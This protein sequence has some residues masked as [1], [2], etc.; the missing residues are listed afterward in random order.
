[1]EGVVVTARRDDANFSV[2]VVS[3]AQ[4]QYRFPRTHVEPG[5][6]GVTMRAVGYDLVAPAQVTVGVDTTASLDLKLQKASDLVAQ[7]TSIEFAMSFPGPGEQIDKF[8]HQR[9]SCAYCHTYNRIVKSKHSAEQ[10]MAVIQRM[11]SYYPDGA[12]SSDDGRGSWRRWETDRFVRDSKWGLGIG[13]GGEEIQP[14]IDK[15]E[16]A[17]FLATINMSGG[18]TNLPY[19][20]KTLPRPSGKETRVIITQYD[21]PRKTTVAHDMEIDSTGTPW[22]TDETAQFLGTLDPSTATFTEYPMP[23]VGE[24]D[25]VGT[26]DITFDDEDN[27]WFPMRVPGGASLL[28]KFDVRTKTVTTLEDVDAQF[29]A[30]GGDGKIWSQYGFT[31]INPQTLM[32]EGR[33]SWDRAPNKPEG[34]CCQYQV[35]A[36]SRGH[37]YI[38]AGN[39]VVG[40]DP[41]TGAAEFWP[42]PTK[43]SLPRRGRMDPQDRYWFAQYNGDGI[44]M[45]D[46]QTKDIQEWN[47]RKYS[48]PYT[49]SVPDRNGY[50]YASS[51]MSERLI[52]LDPTTGEIV[53]YLMPTQ[54]DSKKIAV[55][56][57]TDRT[58]LWMANTRNARLLKVEPLD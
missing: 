26:R 1:M 56:P 8:V 57:A 54:F 31:L 27:P 2:S 53:E 20:L 15:T 41:D 44:G 22:Y 18:R 52:R 14:G 55:H 34:A 10:F 16:L 51:N 6:Y 21:M 58:I 35:V 9:L 46:T 42:I 39:Y 45:F 36:D 17:E 23:P 48:T 12:A 7:L 13:V 43:N 28:T 50:V 33:F 40:I 32:V 30:T 5:R 19:E 29:I 37:P 3:D 25:P 11:A 38:A 47:V 49:V 24:H 4:G